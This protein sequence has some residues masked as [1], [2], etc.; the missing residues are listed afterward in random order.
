MKKNRYRCTNACCK[1]LKAYLKYDAQLNALRCESCGDVYGYTATKRLS[2]S[3]LQKRKNATTPHCDSS[4]D[5]HG[6]APTAVMGTGD[7]SSI[8]QSCSGSRCGHQSGQVKRDFMAD[9][10]ALMLCGAAI[11]LSCILLFCVRHAI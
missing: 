9:D 1:K 10:V 11:V 4:N 7:L 3:I 8:K 6:T 5:S 2:H